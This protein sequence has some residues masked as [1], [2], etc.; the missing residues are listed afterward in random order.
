[1]LDSEISE[2]HIVPITIEPFFS[3]RSKKSPGRKGSHIAKKSESIF[4]L[5]PA[6][7]IIGNN[8]VLIAD[9]DPF[10]LMVLE[11]LFNQLGI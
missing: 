1:M 4:R 9:D 6:F 3:P 10:N 7:S 2:R 11:G 8:K 5:E